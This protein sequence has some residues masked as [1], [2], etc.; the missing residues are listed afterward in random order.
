M[1]NYDKSMLNY[2]TSMLNYDA[3]DTYLF[4]VTHD[5]KT[6]ANELNNDLTKIN[7]WAFQWKMYLDYGDIK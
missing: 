6:S 3:D 4:A 1:L 2:D 7:N 5:I